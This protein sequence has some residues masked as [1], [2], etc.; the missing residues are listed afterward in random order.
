MAA[1]NHTTNYNLPQYIGTDKPTYLGDWNSTMGAIDT[2]MKTNA[3]NASGALSAAQTAQTNA[4]SA[5]S[6]AQ[7]A[8]SKADTALTNA[9]TAQSTADNA[10]SVATSALS[11]A[12]TANGK[13]DNNTTAISALDTRV[14]S[15]ET[16][17]ENLTP[18]VL[19]DNSTG[20]ATNI[21][22]S[23]SASN[24]DYLEIY[25]LE[26]IYNVG[27]TD[28]WFDN[29]IKLNLNHNN[30]ILQEFY[31]ESNATC[32]YH[33]AEY[34]VNGTSVTRTKNAFFYITPSTGTM[35]Y[36]GNYVADKFKITKILGYK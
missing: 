16:N 1:T 13:S 8:D 31:A 29:S 30:F 28:E 6:T 24:Y 12:N 21:T 26:D 22:L 9:A 18:V 27:S 14:T 33:Y 17:I 35:G 32:D 23:D 25:Y 11:T 15:N 3:D 7:S 34:E 20:S 36:D 19:Y 10:T 2:Q 4:N 5:L